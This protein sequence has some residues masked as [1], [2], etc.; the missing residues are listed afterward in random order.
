MKPFYECLIPS[1]GFLIWVVL[2]LAGVRTFV[3][4]LKDTTP[5]TGKGYPPI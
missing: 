5:I 1:I 2:V 3:H 4:F